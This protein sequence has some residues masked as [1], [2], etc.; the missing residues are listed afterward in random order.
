MQGPPGEKHIALYNPETGKYGEVI[1]ANV[2]TA[3]M[4]YGWGGAI[5][6]TRQ[7]QGMPTYPNNWQG[8]T[9]FGVNF[10]QT[11][12]TD[13]EIRKAVERYQAGDH[14]NAYIP[15]LIGYEAY[16]HHPNQ[17][18]Y[19]ASRT[20]DT[21]TGPN[22]EK[23]CVSGETKV[24]SWGVGGCKNRLFN[25]EGIL[26]MGG[27]FRLDPNINVQTQIRGD[28]TAFGDMMAR[29]IARTL[30]KHG[31]TMTDQTEAGFALVAEHVRKTDGTYDT[32]SFYYG[33]GGQWNYG[34]SWLKPML[35]QLIDNK[36]LQFVYTGRNL[37]VDT[38]GA[39]PAGAYRPPR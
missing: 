18:Y 32:S 10:G 33:D 19:P 35:L 22:Y 17:W 21:G 12:I 27:I 28:G 30:Q 2:G 20:D 36:W 13:H 37:E 39:P 24:S 15:H 11:V 3:S 8:A 4:S 1:G 5:Q 7:S 6:D 38:G 34:A 29:I 31:A 14:A 23:G 26:R 25:G 16:R 9:A